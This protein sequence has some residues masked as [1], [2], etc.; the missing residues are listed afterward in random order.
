MS[1]IT[2]SNSEYRKEIRTLEKDGYIKI[3]RENERTSMGKLSDALNFEKQDIF[4][5]RII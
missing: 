4:I 2:Y 5:E 3:K 1:G